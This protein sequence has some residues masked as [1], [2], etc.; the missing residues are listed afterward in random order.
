MILVDTSV[1]AD[2]FRKAEPVLVDLLRAGQ[3]TTHAFVIGE[4]AV[5]SLHDWELTLKA[6]DSLPRVREASEEEWRGTVQRHRLAGSGLGFVD[7][8]LLAAL[9]RA[10]NVR[11]WARDKKLN[12]VAERLSLRA[13]LG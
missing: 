4:L 13:D 1:W 10:N 5:G 7:C 8:H 6:L 12:V 3:V 2:H 11:L 9:E